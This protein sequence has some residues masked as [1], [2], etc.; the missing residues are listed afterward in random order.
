MA[1]DVSP[2]LTYCRCGHS[3]ANH[4]CGIEM[5]PCGYAYRDDDACII[6]CQCEAYYLG[7]LLTQPGYTRYEQRH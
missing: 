4:Q 3:K 5:G 7:F 2:L 6:H 1:D